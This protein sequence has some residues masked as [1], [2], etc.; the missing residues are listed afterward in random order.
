MAADLGCPGR[1]GPVAALHAL[2]ETRCDSDHHAPS[3]AWHACTGDGTPTA[4]RR[5]GDLVP[6]SSGQAACPYRVKRAAHAACAANS[7][8]ISGGAGTGGHDGWLALSA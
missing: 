7:W 3:D 5:R 8:R 2:N 6:V 4:E 1:R